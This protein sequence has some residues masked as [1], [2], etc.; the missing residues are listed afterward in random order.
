V[1]YDRVAFVNEWF[2]DPDICTY[3]DMNIYPPP[4]VCPEGTYNMWKGYAI[5]KAY[6]PSSKN[7]Q[8]FFNH[9]KIFVNDDEKG[10]DYMIKWLAQLFQQ[11]GKLTGTAPIFRGE[12]GTGKNLFFDFLIRFMVGEN[13]YFQTCNPTQDLFERFSNGRLNRFLVCVD[14]TKG[15][16]SCSNNEKKEKC[17]D[18]SHYAV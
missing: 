13:L 9:L 16:D 2:K 11:P 4:M 3:E 14:E 7:L 5:E 1:T 18:K 12:Q 15:K 8:P 10:F 17:F 6:A